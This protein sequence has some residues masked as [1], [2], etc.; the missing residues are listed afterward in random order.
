[1]E[2]T[3]N[4]GNKS[5]PKDQLE[6]VKLNPSNG[7]QCS[8]KE[9]DLT[10]GKEI[11]LKDQLSSVEENVEAEQNSIAEYE[12]TEQLI[13]RRQTMYEIEGEKECLEMEE[14][15]K[16][17]S[18]SRNIRL[19]EISMNNLSDSDIIGD[20]SKLNDCS[21]DS[22]KHNTLEVPTEANKP[23]CC[24]M[25]GL[26]SDQLIKGKLYIR[27][28]GSEEERNKVKTECAEEMVEQ[29]KNKLMKHDNNLIIESMNIV[30]INTQNKCM[31][32]KYINELLV[33]L[34]QLGR[35]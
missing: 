35:K 25:E 19:S 11:N 15:V 29:I 4:E 8:N 14:M 18:V 7:D 22:P 20:I 24:A 33:D 16:R 26:D 28:I 27:A 30:N 6:E 2:E 9:L 23:M 10:V 3:P 1:M 34:K 31:N 13:N 12:N 5:S 21:K 17:G 32:N